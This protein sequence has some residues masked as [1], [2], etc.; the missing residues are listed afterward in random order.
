MNGQRRSINTL[1]DPVGSLSAGIREFPIDNR[2]MHLGP[3]FHDVAGIISG[4]PRQLTTDEVS[5]I[6]RPFDD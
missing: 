1:L 2:G 3:A 6:E 5:R 4:N